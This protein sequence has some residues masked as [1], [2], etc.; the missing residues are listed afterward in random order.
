MTDHDDLGPPRDRKAWSAR[1]S[2]DFLGT[3]SDLVASGASLPGGLRALA[4]E[5]ESA[6]LRHGLRRV[7]D[8]IERG[9]TLAG[10]IEAEGDRI[11]EHLPA[12]AHAAVRSGR[13]QDL[14]MEALRFERMGVELSRQILARLAYP[15]LLLCGFA[16]LF[17]AFSKFVISGYVSI[18]EDFGVNLGP[19]TLALV[20]ISRWVDASGWAIPV[21]CVVV[22]S[23]AWL[24]ARRAS[25]RSR[26]RVVSAIPLVGRLWWNTAMAE[27]AG[28]LAILVDARVT[29]PEALTLAARGVRDADL[30][31]ACEGAAA[32]VRAGRPLL[33]ASRAYRLFPHGFDRLLGWAEANRAL[34]DAFRLASDVYASR[35]RTQAAMVGIFLSAMVLSFV[36]IGVFLVLVGLYTPLLK[37]I[38]ELSG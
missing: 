28:L 34:P 15:T 16:L 14:L 26:R 17:L 9:A 22:V 4:D 37:L 33:D 25:R 35:A 20:Q 2:A 19:L 8:R 23:L 13:P 24:A 31:A 32:E 27:F 1:E 11:P 7:A 3:V 29:L 18:Y 30:I 12:I 6:R 21:G 38:S 36:V 5:S 10:A